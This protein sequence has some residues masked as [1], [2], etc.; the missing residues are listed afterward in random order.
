MFIPLKKPL[1]FSVLY[2]WRT[3][4]KNPEYLYVCM[5]VFTLSR[6]KAEAV[7]ST[8]DMEAATS[9]RYFLTRRCCGSREASLSYL[10]S[11]LLPCEGMVGGGRRLGAFCMVVVRGSSGIISGNGGAPWSSRSP[12]NDLGRGDR[13][14]SPQR[15]RRNGQLPA[16]EGPSRTP[17]RGFIPFFKGGCFYPGGYRSNRTKENLQNGRGSWEEVIRRGGEKGRSP[18]CKECR[19]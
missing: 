3:Q 2:V 17:V 16:G 9:V 10:L 19:R 18:F 7:D 15:G 14:Q 11:L 12:G 8:L 5:R 13:D 1:S 6:G 4:S